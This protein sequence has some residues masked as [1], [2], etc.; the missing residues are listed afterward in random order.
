M[1]EPP[2]DPPPESDIL[3]IMGR[4]G[5]AVIFHLL[6]HCFDLSKDMNCKYIG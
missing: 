1:T 6:F 4:A 2:L 5:E 3:F